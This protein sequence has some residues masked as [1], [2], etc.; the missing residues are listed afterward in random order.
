MWTSTNVQGPLA[1]GRMTVNNNKPIED[2]E[3]IDYPVWVQIEFE[4]VAGQI[5]FLVNGTDTQVLFDIGFAFHEAA[6]HLRSQRD[7]L[8]ANMDSQT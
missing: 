8:D 5:N 3:P 1:S 7:A 6:T 4:N 2:G